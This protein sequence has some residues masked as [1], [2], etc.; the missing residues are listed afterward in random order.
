MNAP[1]ELDIGPLS[2]VKDE[3]ELALARVAEQLQIYAGQQD[4]AVF[5]DARAYLHQAH[6]A[7]AIVGLDGVTEFSRAIERLLDAVAEGEVPWSLSLGEAA[8]A[9]IAALRQYLDE[10]IAGRP[11]Q[12]LRL[13]PV[14]RSLNQ[15]RSVQEVVASD[16]FFPDLTQ[17]PPKRDNPSTMLDP[18]AQ[19]ARLKAARLGF[20]R[21]L[22]KWFKQGA[23]GENAGVRDMRNSIAIIEAMQT[24]PSTRAFWWVTLAYFDALAAGGIAD[25]DATRRLC[26]RIDAQVRKLLDGAQA[27]AERLMRD[28]LYEVATTPVSNEHIDLVRA[29]YRLHDLIPGETVAGNPGEKILREMRERLVAASESWDQFCS[30]AAVALPRFHDHSAQL[31]T[32]AQ[33]LGNMDLARLVAGLA[34][35][36]NLLRK[37]P[38]LH[39]D[40]LAD[41]VATALL[42]S[43]SAVNHFDAL[44]PEFAAQVDV[45]TGRL[46]AVQRGDPLEKPELP[47]LQVLAE[48]AASRIGMHR[49]SRDLR[50]HLVLVEQ[51]LDAFFRDSTGKVSLEGEAGL[52]QKIG[53]AFEQLAQPRAVEI[54]RE[55]AQQV[56][57]FT[58]P[59][60]QRSGAEFEEVA[61]KISALGFFVEQL[62]RGPADLD[63]ILTP[64]APAPATVLPSPT[65]EAELS[66]M[67]R[68]ARTLVGVM[69]GKEGPPPA[70]D[71]ARESL[72]S[73]LKQ[74][75]EGVRDNARLVADAAME[76]QADA[77]LEALDSKAAPERM[78]EIVAPLGNNGWLA[79]VADAALFSSESVRLADASADEVDSELLAIFIEEVL[80]VLD[81]VGVQLYKSMASPDKSEHVAILRRCFH[82]LKGSSRMVGLHDFSEAARAVESTLARHLQTER[83]ATPELHAM[84]DT[85]QHIVSDWVERLQRHA[86]SPNTAPLLRLCEALKQQDDE[87]DLAREQGMHEP[88]AA[89]DADEV[90]IGTLRIRRHLVDIYLNEARGHLA[91]LEQSRQPTP[92]L[93]TQQMIRAAHSL[94]GSS[95]TIGI[96]P[97]RSLAQALELALERFA[98]A[99]AVPD[100]AQDTTLRHA[101]RRMASMVASVAEHNFPAADDELATL[102][103]GMKPATD[104]TARP[105]PPSRSEAVPV[106]P[107]DHG[108]L[109]LFL[110]EC[111]ELVPGIA[112]GFKRWRESGIGPGSGS[113]SGADRR[114][115]NPLLRQLHTLKGSARMAGVMDVGEAVHA[116][117]THVTEALA[118]A[119]ASSVVPALIEPLEMEFDKVV[120]LID[121]LQAIP[122]AETAGTQEIAR[123]MLRVRAELVDTMVSES[124]EIAIA[125]SRLEGG[126]KALRASL[127]DLTDN[128]SRLR[129]HL[130]ELEV[131]SDA[132]IQSQIQ[133]RSGHARDQQF[134]PL[135]MDRYTRLQELTRILAESVNDVATVEQNLM[136]DLDQVDA[137]LTQQARLSRELTQHLMGVRM[138][139]F[140][141]IGERL[142]RVLRQTAHETGKQAVL[143]IEGGETELDRSV[144]ERMTGPIEHLLRNAVVHG[145]ESA[146]VRAA[147]G[148][149]AQ[150]EVRLALVQAGNEVEIVISDDG[151]GLDYEGIRN[152]AIRRGLLSAGQSADETKL[153]QLIYQPGFTTASKLSAIAGRGVGMDVVRT[154]TMALGGRIEVRARPKRGTSFSLHLPL[155]L[156]VIPALLV[157]S[158][159]RTYAMPSAMVVQASEMKP[160]AMVQLR[161]AGSLEWQGQSYALHYLPHL[162]GD[163]GA[164][165]AAQR[166]HW[167]ILLRGGVLRI[168]L[169][170][171]TLVG[172]EEVVIK[173]IGPQLA[174]VP[175]ISGATVMADGEVVLIINPVTLAGRSES[176]PSALIEHAPVGKAARDATLPPVVM[177]V[178]DSLTVRKIT[179]R[180]VERAGY[181]LMT[182]KDGVDALEQLAEAV[183]DVML[184]DIEMPRMDGF[185]LL[186]R[187]RADSRFKALPVIMITSRTA[188]K[189]RNYA[190][191]MGA[192]EYLGKP[193]D[194]EGLLQMIAQY[195]QQ[196]MV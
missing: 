154:E 21:G 98:L 45:I 132:S 168:A 169:E 10:L 91:I 147:N 181:R 61:R 75:L 116:V 150:G 68:M 184:A 77:A 54:V 4:K 164:Q 193:Y 176:A 1:A 90:S 165:P 195:A 47:A 148:K 173:N 171:D 94:S 194:E 114:S 76:R 42:L 99:G 115:S 3:I 130:R 23:G 104:D 133:G 101:L 144:L 13:L 53:A 8:Q 38:L 143:V 141:S 166:R 145:I 57:T 80:Q 146:D 127:S 51:G 31:V 39:T 49:L 119:G 113:G 44:D 64:A 120:G 46:N 121:A 159:T 92:T 97:L 86:S 95:G 18:Q 142:Q 102:L 149:V 40:M 151:G 191:E 30:G 158:G 125:R 50:A 34:N 175:G 37:N 107:V 12:P 186:R 129:A 157:K 180:L 135:E 105:L 29:A 174:R 26:G 85:A 70:N 192:N 66:Q 118:K 35:T 89:S 182:A 163:A 188:D 156:A 58:A 160:E 138:V 78:E 48:R 172:N 136:R 28:V 19:Q 128:V 7:L 33:Q 196:P 20:E 82:T 65:V 36:A 117:E 25:D 2:W 100:A 87:A 110:E 109:P 6:G 22:A 60:H 88:S 124:G 122:A 103:Q 81:T 140:A 123:P 67:A 17:R 63:A 15:A 72:R 137:A 161:T 79:R 11:N 126:A 152:E 83:P 56:A 16:L 14:Y 96:T 106:A 155:T 134:D 162:L 59:G 108:L 74:N 55:C 5:A 84:V 32:Q 52:L 111:Q 178:D 43:E 9:G 177:V 189:H 185:E 93:P 170:V 139:P 73:E 131:Q 24:Q 69:M 112:A 27:V 190:I 62:Q 179:G 183:P 167:V 71:E 153:A 187:L 41:E